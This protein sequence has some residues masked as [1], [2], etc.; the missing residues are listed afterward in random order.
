MTR[1]AVYYVGMV[2]Q[3]AAERQP[4]PPSTTTYRG[5]N[6]SSPPT[7]TFPIQQPFSPVSPGAL[8]PGGSRGAPLPY[9]STAGT[10]GSTTQQILVPNNLV[11]AIIGRG[12]N[13]INAIRQM[14]QSHIKV[15]EPGAG[16]VGSP[17]ERV[18]SVWIRRTDAH[19]SS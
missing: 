17:N 19:S 7:P 5:P 8:F 1:A 4:L 2:L 10:P 14:S 3:E 11:G 16:G 6:Y 9:Q 15:M 12:G 18:R 13:Q